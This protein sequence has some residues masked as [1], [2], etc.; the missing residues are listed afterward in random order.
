M[1]DSNALPAAAH[2]THRPRPPAIARRPNY[3]LRRLV[4][5][6]VLLAALAVAAT[7]GAG[8]LTGFGG[9]PASASGAGSATT[10]RTHLVQPGDT[11]WEIAAEHHGRVGLVTYLEALIDDN[12]GPSIEPGELIR[13]P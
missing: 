6:L 9:D 8:L 2:R 11:L 1:I 12:G 7:V 4:A 3:A 13:L 10:P 5:V